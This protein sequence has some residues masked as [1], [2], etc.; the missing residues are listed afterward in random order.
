MKKHLPLIIKGLPVLLITSLTAYSESMLPVDLFPNIAGLGIGS[1][2]EFSGA[3]DRITGAAPGL[4][5]KLSGYRYVEWW[6]P[7]VNVNVIDSPHWRAGPTLNYRFGRS[8]VE[9]PAVNLLPEIDGTL[10]GGAFATYSHT[11]TKG[12]PWLIRMGV[13]G[14]TD[15]GNEHNGFSATVF[16]S[17]WMPLSRTVF[18]GL[19]GGAVYGSRDFMQ[20]YY[21]VTTAG[22][23]ASGLSPYSPGGGLRN[24]FIWPAVIWKFDK[25]WA[26]GTMLFY[27]R[28]TGA[29]ADSPIVRDRGTAHQLTGGIG[30]GYLWK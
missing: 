20:T 28:L 1:T 2:P 27:Q 5:Y 12:I 19:G 11:N 25:N 18:V 4:R 30:I 29:A 16:G 10:E 9:D 26:A 24:Y 22:A 21:G 17:I 23:A 13:S 8:D 15:L 6:G 3:K 14:M 7:L